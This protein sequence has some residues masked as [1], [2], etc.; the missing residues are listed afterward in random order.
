MPFI[1]SVRGNFGPLKK[2]QIAGDPELKFRITGGN[3]ITVAGGYR[4]HTFSSTGAQTF[5][6]E[7]YQ[8]TLA[9]EYLVVA[10]GGTGGDRH[11]S[12]GGGAG[13]Y[14]ASSL[15]VPIGSNPVNVGAGAPEG[16]F[17]SNNPNGGPSTFSS[18]TSTGG[19]QGASYYDWQASPGGSGGG[20]GAHTGGGGGGAGGAGAAASTPGGSEP[21]YTYSIPGPGTPGQGNN[22]G[23]G[24]QNYPNGTGGPGG[25]GIYSPLVGYSLAGGGGGASWNP[26]TPDKRGSGTSGGGPG[27]G[28]TDY[29]AATPGATNYG[30]GGGGANGNPSA[31]GGG[32]PG[33]VVVR[34]IV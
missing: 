22:G 26:G 9:T 29:T 16:A 25:A 2:S 28:G 20:G 5:G 18:I 12:G 34:Y 23:A 8:Y 30:G 3:S 19:G 27:R 31:G 11:G 1:S 4:I 14:R 21:G 17:P 33:I 7:N 10:G 32:G 13:G 15:T 24:S 6:T